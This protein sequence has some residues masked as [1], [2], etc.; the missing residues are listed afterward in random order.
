M[1]RTH[2]NYG[3]QREYGRMSGGAFDP[4]YRPPTITATKNERTWS[5]LAHL[6]TFINTFTGFL[7]PLAAF[8]IWLA[9]RKSSPMV[10][11]H[12]MRSVVYQVVWL[13][14]I[15]VG[16]TITMALTAILVGYLLWPVMALITIAPFVHAS[17]AA[18]DAWKENKVYL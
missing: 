12:A 16:W 2:E 4:S 8:V 13:S 17:V 1:S 18:Y 15:A 6:T 14:V 3:M 9:N 10:A 7:G 11:S 5:I